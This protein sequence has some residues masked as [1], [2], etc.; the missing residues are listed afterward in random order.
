MRG[1]FSLSALWNC[2]GTNFKIDSN[3][4]NKNRFKEKKET[5]FL[6]LITFFAFKY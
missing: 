2:T 1:L 4:Y 3:I 6:A 5:L